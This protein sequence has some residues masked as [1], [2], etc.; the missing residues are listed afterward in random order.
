M[1]SKK[2][3]MAFNMA[4]QQDLKTKTKSN[5]K[6]IIS[7]PATSFRSKFP[8]TLRVWGRVPRWS[9]WKL[10]PLIA[11]RQ[12]FMARGLHVQTLLESSLPQGAYGPLFFFWVW[13]KP[14]SFK[15]NG[16]FQTSQCLVKIPG[17]IL[18]LFVFLLLA[19]L[20]LVIVNLLPGITGILCNRDCALHFSWW[21]SAQSTVFVFVIC[22]ESAK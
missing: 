20:L 8:P 9:N 4:I 2:I 21:I 17:K 12:G 3:P 13:S 16:I 22:C 6:L 19:V 18:N 1:D 7:W 15:N 11:E 14:E 5:K 10:F